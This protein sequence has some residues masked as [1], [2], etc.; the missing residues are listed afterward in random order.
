MKIDHI[1]AINVKGRSFNHSLASLTVI[2][3]GNATGKT[4]ITDAIVVGAIGH[5][6]K[7]GKTNKATWQLAGA[8]AIME[9]EVGFSDGTTRRLTLTSKGKSIQKTEVGEAPEIELAMFD[10]QSFIHAPIKDK[11]ETIARCLPAPDG[12]RSP[13]D[14]LDDVRADFPEIEF[15]EFGLPTDSFQEMRKEAEEVR[16]GTKAERRMLEETITGLEQLGLD[17]ED[18]GTTYSEAQI[19]DKERDIQ[20]L[21]AQ[22]QEA[23]IALGNCRKIEGGKPQEEMPEDIEDQI[24]TLGAEIDR[25]EVDRRQLRDDRQGNRTH[26]AKISELKQKIEAMKSTFSTEI[27]A[28]EAHADSEAFQPTDIDQLKKRQDELLIE[29]RRIAQS[30]THTNNA[31]EAHRAEWQALREKECCPVCQSTGQD[32]AEAIDRIMR[33]KSNTLSEKLEQLKTEA[34]ESYVKFTQI[35]NHIEAEQG[36]ATLSKIAGLEEE[37]TDSEAQ[38]KDIGEQPDYDSAIIETTAKRSGLQKLA[39]AWETYRGMLQVLPDKTADELESQLSHLEP[40]IEDK[41][42]DLRRMKDAN[43]AAAKL[44]HDRQR[45]QESIEKLKKLEEENKALDKIIKDSKDAELELANAAFK[46][47]ASAAATFLDGIVDGELTMSGQDMGVDRE[48]QFI[49]FLT[50]SGA[51]QLAVGSAIKAAIAGGTASK[52]LIADELPRM[53]EENRLRFADNVEQ[54]IAE[55]TLEQAILIDHEGLIETPDRKLIELR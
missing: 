35:A 28:A 4:A 11:L 2:S 22:K 49:G 34:E 40:E 29:D 53:T 15:S 1:K 45:Q 43:S 12:T 27:A 17:D 37:I 32:F 52:I 5:H 39:Q 38:L 54:A 55:G 46:P 7:L 8:G 6:P 26:E 16:R 13:E 9:T 14:V 33:E 30:F 47:L 24:Q 51:E 3:G 42:D 36:R 21:R 50:L 25:L 19:T 10:V 18:Q 44:A 31:L 41:C 23:E 48:G 20:T